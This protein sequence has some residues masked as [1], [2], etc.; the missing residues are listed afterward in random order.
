MQNNSLV[1]NWWLNFFEKLDTDLKLH[2]C[3]QQLFD[4]LEEV[5]DWDIDFGTR[6][7]RSLPHWS[8]DDV[9]ESI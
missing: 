5:N 4:V 8:S 2:Q 9:I 1:S 6:F 7:F 3:I